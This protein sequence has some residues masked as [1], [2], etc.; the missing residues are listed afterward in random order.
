MN[1]A[2]FHFLRFYSFMA[3]ARWVDYAGRLQKLRQIVCAGVEVKTPTKAVNRLGIRRSLQLSVTVFLPRIVF[4]GPAGVDKPALTHQ[5]VLGFDQS[6]LSGRRA[7]SSMT[8]EEQ[9]GWSR[10]NQKP[11][12]ELSGR[13]LAEQPG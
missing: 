4:R 9:S 7:M 1:A 2:V 12:A 13:W 11:T 8:A 6:R 3:L 10:W 5:S